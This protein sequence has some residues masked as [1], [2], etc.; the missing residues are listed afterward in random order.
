M[1]ISYEELTLDTSLNIMTDAP[2]E[3]VVEILTKFQ[4]KPRVPP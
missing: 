4:T 1:L 3:N 2:F